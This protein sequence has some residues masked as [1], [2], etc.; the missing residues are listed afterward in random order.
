M[1]QHETRTTT[2]LAILT[3]TICINNGSGKII[4]FSLVYENIL[5][6]KQTYQAEKSILQVCTYDTYTT[7]P[8][9]KIQNEDDGLEKNILYM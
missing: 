3:S 2:T 7:I 8:C 1:L 6:A 9:N 5:K 4:H